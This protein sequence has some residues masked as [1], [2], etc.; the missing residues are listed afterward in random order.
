M[1]GEQPLENPRQP[2]ESAH[3]THSGRKVAMP[4]KAIV[5]AFGLMMMF[6]VVLLAATVFALM[7]NM[8]GEVR[9]KLA[10]AAERLE[11]AYGDNR[12]LDPVLWAIRESETLLERNDS[13]A[14]TGIIVI[15]VA[16]SFF[17]GIP[18]ILFAFAARL[19][20][21]KYPELREER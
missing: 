4:V 12:D 2:T 1:D 9:S 11:T 13:E 19:L 6:E 14:V 5:A 7:T 17:I 18:V 21:R 8:T 3:A 10:F 15:A 20:F 16:G